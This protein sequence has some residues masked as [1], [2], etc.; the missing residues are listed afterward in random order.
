[1]SR[2]PSLRI[3]SVGGPIAGADA[4]DFARRVGAEPKDVDVVFVAQTVA[5]VRHGLG[6]RYAGGIV[7]GVT[8]AH[9]SNIA[10]LSPA[11]AS[12]AGYDPATHVAVNAG[13]PYTGTVTVRVL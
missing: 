3:P 10:A 5:T 11:T 13:T 6:R 4:V 7:I 8:V 9:G 12:A 2:G 1:M